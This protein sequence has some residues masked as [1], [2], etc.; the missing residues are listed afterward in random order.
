MTPFISQ[1]NAPHAED[2]VPLLPFVWGADTKLRRDAVKLLRQALTPKLQDIAEPWTRCCPPTMTADMLFTT[3]I[4]HVIESLDSCTVS[5]PA[6]FDQWV[7][8]T[9]LRWL[10]TWERQV[11]RTASRSSDCETLGSLLASL[12]EV[13][14]PPH[15][16]RTMKQLLI[17]V[18][19]SLDATDRRILEMRA[20]GQHWRAVAA[21]GRCTIAVVKQRH[22]LALATARDLATAMLRRITLSEEAA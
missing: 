19:A 6:A 21:E 17:D 15:R 14:A 1:S 2:L 20:A 3:V 9:A 5:T 13:V 7:R 10:M 18:L 12:R 22:A 16:D 8:Q 11:R 4:D